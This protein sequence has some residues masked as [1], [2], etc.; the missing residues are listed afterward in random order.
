MFSH[1]NSL[2]AVDAQC[3]HDAQHRLTVVPQV[4]VVLRHGV[5]EGL[6]GCCW[7]RQHPAVLLDLGH[8]DSLGWINHQHLTDQVFTV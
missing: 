2:L 6:A 8:S 7:V 1:L 5:A 4:G 3:V